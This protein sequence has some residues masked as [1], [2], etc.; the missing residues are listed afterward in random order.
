MLEYDKRDKEYEEKVI[1]NIYRVFRQD[2]LPVNHVI[3][4]EKNC[5][6]LKPK[7]VY[8][9]G[10]AVLHWQRHIKRLHPESVVICFDANEDFKFLYEREKVE[11]QI[12]LLSDTDGL[13]YKYYYNRELFGGNSYYREIGCNGG[14]CFPEDRFLIKDTKKLDTL[15]QENN[16]S[17][18]DLMKMD[19]QGAELDIIKGAREVLR[20]CK[21]LIVEL[22]DVEYNRY[23]PKANE[24]IEYLKTIGYECIASKFS[25]NGPDADYCFKNVKLISNII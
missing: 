25:D 19:C 23:A 6:M 7:V 10:A 18:P 11:H 1:L 24:V 20:Y 14:K 22:Q 12:A 2:L 3:F 13:K 5:S 17:I 9:I 16:Y 21:Y 4:L 15:V 8:D